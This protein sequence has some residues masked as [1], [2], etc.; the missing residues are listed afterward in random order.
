MKRLNLFALGLLA[1]L[2]AVPQGARAL[3]FLN[4]VADQTFYVGTP[5]SITLP[6]IDPNSDSNCIWPG[7]VTPHDT[8]IYALTP[9]LPQG[10]SFAGGG[11]TPPGPTLVLSGTPQAVTATT[12]YTY[13]GRDVGVCYLTATDTFN[14]TI[15]AAQSTCSS[16]TGT[17]LQGDCAALETFYDST[18][19]ANWADKTNW[20]TSNSLDTWHG[21]TVYEGRVTQVEL[22]NN[23]LTGTISDLSALTGLVYLDLRSNSLSGT[24]PDLSNTKLRTLRL[25]DNNIS[26]SIPAW[27]N[28][29]NPNIRQLDLYNNKLTGA[30]PD[31]SDIDGPSLDLSN[32][33]LGGGL[34]QASNFPSELTQAPG[35]RVAGKLDLSNNMLTGSL[36]DLS[37]LV[38]VHSMDFSNNQFGGT[39][40]A[41][42]LPPNLDRLNLNNNRLSGSIPDMTSL[43][44]LSFLDLQNNRFSGT[45]PNLSTVKRLVDLGGNGLT[46]SLETDDFHEK[47]QVLYLND[48]SLE[49]SNP[50]LSKQERL[51]RLAL[52]GNTIN[53]GLNLNGLKLHANV[54]ASVIDRGALEEL[55]DAHGGSGWTRKSGW[56][57]EDNLGNWDGVTVDNSGRVTRLDLSNN[58][59]T[60]EIGDSIANLTALKSLSTDPA[61]LNLKN[62]ASLSGTLPPRFVENIPNLPY[63]L[64][65]DISGTGICLPSE[66]I[67][68]DRGNERI[69]PGIVL[70]PNL[71]NVTR[72]GAGGGGNSNNIQSDGLPPVQSAG[73]Q[74]EEVPPSSLNLPSVSFEADNA[75]AEEGESVSFVVK[76]S[77]GDGNEGTAEVSY[78]TQDGTAVAHEDYTPQSGTLVFEEGETSK[79]VTVE[80]NE[81]GAA[82]SGTQRTF[83]ITLSDPVNAQLG[84]TSTVVVEIMETE[85]SGEGGCSVASGSRN[86]G[87]AAL[88][89]LLA[90]FLLLPVFAGGRGRKAQGR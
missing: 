4:T 27:L 39:L 10:L 69:I 82:E 62:N 47:L 73:G 67:R 80:V 44:K 1:F 14:I 64:S 72:C 3:D 22:Y 90:A 45:I 66:F 31:L 36:P 83:Y 33:M 56:I 61:S 12:E 40:N 17:D 43:T 77:G 13:T 46:G 42:H 37:T 5:V 7:N 24:I 21:I 9:A 16:Q 58:G 28:D 74:S 65:I 60:G 86:G 78:S 68:S 84:D 32:N 52:W 25:N 19:G 23:K 89:L 34:P 15:E 49:D 26:G 70:T 20:K 53:R 75:S 8:I 2:L 50:D 54:N 30:I 57:T 11:G 48:N 55:Y 63:D 85:T 87:S 38:G 59:L 41:G 71:S 79:T 51:K 35:R 81:S 29:M 6:Q 18:G 76:I 88:S